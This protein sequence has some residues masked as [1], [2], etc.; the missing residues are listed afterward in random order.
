MIQNYIPVYKSC[1]SARR[2]FSSFLETVD[3]QQCF[4]ASTGFHLAVVVNS[5][6]NGV[7]MNGSPFMDYCMPRSWSEV[8]LNT[9]L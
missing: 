6:S 2:N 4:I 3:G 7:P 1:T 5:C 8:F 9:I